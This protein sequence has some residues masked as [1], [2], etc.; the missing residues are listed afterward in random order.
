[1]TL[2]HIDDT[3]GFLKRIS[4]LLSPGGIIAFADLDLENGQFHDD[5]LEKVHHGFDRG[6]L[7]AQLK[8]AGLLPNSFETI[9]TMVKPDRSME[10]ANYTVFLVTAIKQDDLHCQ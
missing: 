6:E 10:P 1:M 2:H 9:Y 3:A 7:A 8:A 5:P 4:N